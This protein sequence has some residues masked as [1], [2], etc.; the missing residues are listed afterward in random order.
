MRLV[1][2][3][4]AAAAL[5]LTGSAQAKPRCYGAAARDP[6]KPCTSTTRTVTPTPDEALI[7]PNIACTRGEV[8]DMATSCAVG[9]APE[10]AKATVAMLGDSHAAHW[11]AAMQVLADKQQWRVLEIARPH[12]PFSFAAPA[13]TEAG[14][15]D[16]VAW[17]QRI[18]DYLAQNPQISTIFISDNARLPMADNTFASKLDGFVE[19]LQR[20]AAVDHPRLRDPRPAER[21][22]DHARLRRRTPSSASSSPA[23]TARSRASARSSPTR[24]SAPRSSSKPASRRST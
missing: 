4:I 9:V 20:A 11:R 2:A 24:G 18:V 15:G 23:C 16:C 17:N 10:K 13:P 6:L 12:C 22:R 1:A 21:P 7:T 19:S 3:L 5:T 8:G 14:A